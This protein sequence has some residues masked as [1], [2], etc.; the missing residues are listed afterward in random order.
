MVGIFTV[1]CTI[2]AVRT[3][4][5]FC[6]AFFFLSLTF[7]MVGGSFWIAEEQKTVLQ[8]KVQL[9]RISL[10]YHGPSFGSSH[11]AY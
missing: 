4:I 5:L 3:N 9:V 8:H 6:L 7:L 11:S 1:Y 2:C 10:L